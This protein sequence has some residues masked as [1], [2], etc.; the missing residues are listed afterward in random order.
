MSK[1][2]LKKQ[3]EECGFD[4]CTPKPFEKSVH[5]GC[6]QC[7]ALVINGL[8]CHETGCPNSKSARTNEEEDFEA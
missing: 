6:S 1:L 8:A 4:R 5:V 2:S 3:L 7:S